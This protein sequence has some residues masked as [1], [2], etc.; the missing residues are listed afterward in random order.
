MSLMSI[1]YQCIKLS[2]MLNATYGLS[3]QTLN[4]QGMLFVLKHVKQ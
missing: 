1:L 4:T 3:T 2:P